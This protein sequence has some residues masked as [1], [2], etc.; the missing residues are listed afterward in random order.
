MNKK[1]L[2]ESIQKLKPYIDAVINRTTIK[3]GVDDQ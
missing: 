3:V 2:F 1:E